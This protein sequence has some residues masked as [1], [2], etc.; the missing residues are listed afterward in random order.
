MTARLISPRKPFAEGRRKL[1]SSFY[2][3]EWVADRMAAEV[4]ESVERK[5][6]TVVDP[7]CGPG[8]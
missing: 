4:L 8:N 3:K 2:T 6:E 1:I 5:I 7:F